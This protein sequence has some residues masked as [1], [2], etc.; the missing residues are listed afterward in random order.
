[1][2]PPIALRIMIRSSMQE[3]KRE[4]GTRVDVGMSCLERRADSAIA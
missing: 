4:P 3:Y 2:L 1:V